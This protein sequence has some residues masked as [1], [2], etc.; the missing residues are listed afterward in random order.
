MSAP[1]ANARS[2]PVMTIAPTAASAS[3]ATTA[4]LSSAKSGPLSA[5][6]ALGRWSWMSATAGSGRVLRM[7]W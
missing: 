3:A 1:A 4:A 7:C 6:S 5:L 2:L